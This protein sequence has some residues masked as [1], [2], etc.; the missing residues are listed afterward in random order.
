M[1]HLFNSSF[2]TSA[3]LRGL[4]TVAATL[5]LAIPLAGP[6]AAQ[7][8]A[9][10]VALEIPAQP[11]SAALKSLVRQSGVQ[12][13][14]DEDLVAGFESAP[15][16]GTMSVLEALAIMLKSTSLESVDNGDTIVV[17]RRISTA[18]HGGKLRVAVDAQPAREK[19]AE[20]EATLEEV[21]V[22]AQKREQNLQ[23]VPLA[24]SALS[25]AYLEKRDVASIAGLSAV[26]PNLQVQAGANKT[27]GTI[28]IRGGV[29]LNPQLYFEPSAGFYLDGVYI[30]KAQGNLFDLGDLERIE[31]LR[32]PQ[33]TLYGRNTVAGAVSV[34]TKKPTGELGG[35]VQASY[36]NYDFRKIRGSV[37]LPRFGIFSI[38]LSGQIS[39]RN[40]FND[41]S[42]NPY[43]A[44]A[45]SLDSK[46]GLLQI[47]A[48]PLD[49][50]TLDYA[51]DT[52]VIGEQAAAPE[53]YRGTGSLAP[54]LHSQRVR[55]IS[56]DSPNKEYAKNWGHALTGTLDLGS[57]GTLKSISAY[58][59]QDYR[60]ALDLDG[61]PVALAQSSRNSRYWQAS[62]EL[63]LTGQVDR[64]NYVAGVYYFGDRGF[65]YNPQAFFSGVSQVD[66]RFGFTTK[67]YAAYTQFDFHLTDAW[68]LTAGVRYTHE[69]KTVQR[70]FARLAPVSTVVLDYPEG[71]IPALDFS[72]VT[73]QATV[74]YKVNEGLN[75]YAR[76]AQGYRSGGYNAVATNAAD[77]LSP[78]KP[79][80]QDSYELGLKSRFLENRVQVNAAVFQDNMKDLQVSVFRAAASATST[81]IN[82]GKSR[83]RGAELEVVTRPVDSLLVQ[84]SLGYIDPK[85]TKF[86]DRGVEV[87]DNRTFPLAPRHTLA[88]SIDWTAWRDAAGKLDLIVDVQKVSPYYSGIAALNP[89]AGQNAA[90]NVRNPGY[91]LLDARVVFGEIPLRGAQAEVSFWGKN[92]LNERDPSFLTDFG[93]SFQSLTVATFP[94]PRTYGVSVG[95]RF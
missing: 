38:K 66:S 68:T 80:T 5:C 30:S 57:V 59:Q 28:S 45:D 33:G 89:A 20:A 2:G 34:I 8:A 24:I 61:S 63:Q 10:V 54:Y 14:F 70:Y 25:S 41:V 79:Q 83:I 35:H 46:S 95:V 81:L 23:E 88:G 4:L 73:P 75:L 82:A 47:R 49:G 26:A 72:K 94:D 32:G 90:A 18:E 60:D 71:N 31:V 39:K 15:V 48:Q 86:T 36:G 58:R 37:D 13:F 74:S 64:L 65:L 43:T 84:A 51:F 77:L 42:G 27:S 11:L 21:V 52:S 12:M 91:T 17:R 19:P 92:L 56:F 16:S 3:L 50:L 44:A 22:T 9:N 62:Q 1:R 78:F 69:K 40:G 7:K 87:A 76:Y 53:T 93:A 29:Q 85:Y 6:A 55:R 67:A